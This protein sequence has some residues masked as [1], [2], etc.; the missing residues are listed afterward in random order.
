MGSAD[1][2]AVH[3]PGR[4]D[5]DVVGLEPV[6]FPFDFI[7]YVALKEQHDL[8]EFVIMDGTGPVSFVRYV[9]QLQGLRQVARFF[10]HT[11]RLRSLQ[12]DLQ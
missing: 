11:R 7:G 5:D 12:Q 4:H 8:V 3:L 2:G 1:D 9:K 6:R 10:I